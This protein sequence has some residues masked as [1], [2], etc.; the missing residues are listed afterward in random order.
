MD[1]EY[2]LCRVLFM[3]YLIEFKPTI[4]IIRRPILNLFCMIFTCLWCFPFGFS[5]FLPLFKTLIPMCC[6][7][8][9]STIG[10]L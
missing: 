3:V 10:V 7:A 4:P 8:H 1:K 5:F 2:D 6:A 9:A